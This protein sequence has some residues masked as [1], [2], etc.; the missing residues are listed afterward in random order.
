MS[1]AVD[2]QKMG[3]VGLGGWFIPPI[4]GFF[5]TI[6]LTGWNL[7][8]AFASLDGLRAIFAAPSDDPLA[9]LKIPLAVSL[10]FGLVVMASSAYCLA[11]V[12]GKKRAIVKV[13]TFNY[14]AV[15]IAGLVEV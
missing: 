1:S 3:A 8:Q 5:G 6:I 2:E 14:I 15:A 4:L 7:V 9:D 12:F 13:A 11:L 10:A